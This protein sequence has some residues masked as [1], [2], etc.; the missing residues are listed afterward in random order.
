[1]SEHVE[2]LWLVYFPDESGCWGIGSTEAEARA[3]AVELRRLDGPPPCGWEAWEAAL[4]AVQLV[5]VR[6]VLRA[7]R[8][9]LDS[10]RGLPWPGGEG[11]KS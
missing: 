4:D 9:D 7:V 11:C 8:A 5:G 3:N 2:S 1:M 6:R 10:A